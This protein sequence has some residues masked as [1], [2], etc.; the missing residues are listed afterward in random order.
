MLT[1][2]QKG[3]LAGLAAHRKYK[4]QDLFVNIK[5]VFCLFKKKGSIACPDG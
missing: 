3:P 5:F 4:A 2:L 1:V